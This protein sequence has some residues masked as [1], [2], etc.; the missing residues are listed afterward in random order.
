MTESPIMRGLRWILPMKCKSLDCHYLH[1]TDEESK[2][3]RDWDHAV[4][5]YCLLAWWAMR[6]VRGIPIASV[7]FVD[8]RTQ[9]RNVESLQ[10]MRVCSLL[11]PRGA[12]GFTGPCALCCLYSELWISSD[13]WPW[14]CIFSMVLDVFNPT[15]N[16]SS[17]TISLWVL[18]P[19]LLS[20]SYFIYSLCCFG[21]NFFNSPVLSSSVLWNN[22]L[23]SALWFMQTG[24][25]EE[26]GHACPFSRLSWCCS[27]FLA[28]CCPLVAVWFTASAGRQG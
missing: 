19:C 9:L 4:G 13:L 10:A 26:L 5:G 1:L 25:T 22:V 23:S 18:H 28:L 12:A 14:F 15:L 24:P 17:N 16:I 27:K 21:L 3:Y 8:H 20:V 2:M 7:G 11:R 6:A